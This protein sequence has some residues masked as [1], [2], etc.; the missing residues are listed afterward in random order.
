MAGQLRDCLGAYSKIYP[1]KSGQLNVG[2]DALVSRSGFGDPLPCFSRFITNN[3]SVTP[4]P[5]LCH[6]VQLSALDWFSLSN[7][8]AL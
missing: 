5:C 6:C 7:K 8:E 4:G 3:D 2:C 1:E